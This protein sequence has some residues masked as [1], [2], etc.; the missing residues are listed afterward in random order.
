MKR[1]YKI[2]ITLFLAVSVLV[3]FQLKNNNDPEKDRILIGLL[4]YV[5]T[6][7]HYQP[8]DINDAFSIQVFNSFTES[9]DPAK[10]F[11]IQSDIDEFSQQKTLI[12]DQIKVENISFFNLVQDRLM[13]RMKEAR[14]FYKKILDQPFDFNTDENINVDFEKQAYATNQNELINVWKKQLKH[15]TLVRLHEKLEEEI[16]KKQKD[17]LYVSKPFD[18]LEKEARESTLK[19]LNEFFD[20]MDELD[21]TEWFSNYINSIAESFDPHT[22][23]LAPKIKKRFDISM[24]GKLEG[25]GAILQKRNDFTRVVEVVSGGPAWR[26]GE[27]EVGDII[28]KVAQGNQ[29][30]LDIVGMRL[31]DAIEFIKGKKGTEARLTIKK[32]DGTI[33]VISII[34]DIVEI[35]ETF[36]KSTIVNY[37]G[38]SYGLIN[39]PKFYIDFEEKSSRN[40]ATDMAKEVERLK[41]EKV[42]GF[43]IDLRDNGGGSLETAIDI[44]GL[45]ITEGPIVQVKYRDEEPMIKNDTDKKI[46][47]DGSL[48]VL[49]N[50]LSASA[51]EIF[52][53]AMQDYKRAIIIGSKQ[54]F[55]KGTVQNLLP[56]NNYYRYSDDLGAL[57]ITIQK[58]YRVNGGSTQLKGVNA[59]IALP[60][61]YTY[62]EFGERDQKNPLGW[63]KIKE[64][65]YQPWNNYENLNDVIIKSNH[66]VS[67]NESFKLIDESAKWL[68]KN[69]DQTIVSLKYDLFKKDVE[70]HKENSRKFEAISKYK[71]NLTFA[72]PKYEVPLIATDSILSK[73][74]EIW[75]Q[76]LSKD[77]YVEEALR[78][79]SEL[80]I[81][82]QLSVKN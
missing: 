24:A 13:I 14:G 55:G 57:K 21:H 2:L 49:V 54:T 67:Q 65:K 48:V 8:Q 31:D 11:F 43:I 80:K 23:Y 60:D 37:E 30:P 32:I 44:A 62:M 3:G 39:L 78:V 19:N 36:V 71:N 25:I 27:L 59:D 61:R 5:L 29:E 40:S 75:H 72:S 41:Q 33:K 34:R 82:R 64:V 42:E 38:K 56:L 22:S 74:R 7:G 81:K 58:F 12:D 50:E 63:D 68:K 6:N 51:S 53:A 15:S 46:Y 16:T 47:W 20:F 73:K 18:E 9:V 1:Y 10:R 45:F 69:Q 4:R 66:R 35:E 28:L 79:L 17:S 52:A 77:I 76:N 26:A 70:N